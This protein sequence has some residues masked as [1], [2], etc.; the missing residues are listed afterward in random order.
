[1]K[2]LISSRKTFLTI[3]YS[4]II[5]V[6][7]LILIN[8]YFTLNNT[9]F[10]SLLPLLIN[11]VFIIAISCVLI[12][13]LIYFRKKI[14]SVINTINKIGER[15]FDE[16]L[17]EDDDSELGELT[18]SLNKMTAHIRDSYNKLSERVIARSSEITL[19]NAE[20]KKKQKEV[21]RQQQELKSAYEALNESRERYE[22]LI[23]N[24]EGE[25]FFYSQ[26]ARGELLFVS[27]SI[28]NILG[29]NVKEFRQKR[30]S[31]YTNNPINIEAR[32]HFKKSLLGEQQPKYVVELQDSQNNPHLLEISEVPVFN[33]NRE[34]VS[35]EGL[36]HDI[37]ERYQAEELIKEKEEKYRMLFNRASDFIFLYEIDNKHN[38]A[39]KFIEVNDYTLNR[40]GYSREEMLN[41]SPRDLVFENMWENE[42]EI[43]NYERVWQSKEGIFID[44]EISSHRFRIKGQ[45]VAIAVARDIS[46]RKKSEEEIRFMNEE[47]INQKENLEALVDNLTQTQEQ[48]VQSEKMAALGQ[49]IAGIAHEINTPLGAIKASIG[50]LDDSIEK[51]LRELPSILKNSNENNLELLTRIL[52]EANYN[53]KDLTSRERRQKRREISKILTD[54]NID[55][56]DSIADMIIYTGFDEKY[57]SILDLLKSHSALETL[58]IA[59]NFISLLKNTKTINLAAEKA[60]KVVFALKKYAHKDQEE[61]K[62]P[63]DII[64]N[65]E[66]VLT[67]YHN[68]LKQGINVVRNYSVIPEVACYQDELN[69]V[70]TNLIHNAIQAMDQEGTLT[71]DVKTETEM[72]IINIS[73]TGCGIEPD[74]IDRI[75]D[76]FFTTKKQGEGSGLGLDIVKRI[77]EKHEGTISVHS[78]LNA[79][80]TF[81]IKIPVNQNE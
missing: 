7:I 79:G 78:E 74:I 80:S 50:N 46:E 31:L 35:V 33:E 51:A 59:R 8:L 2:R 77:I 72:I 40:L 75:F 70:W 17:P 14:K 71:I 69:Q 62:I 67:L 47:L 18:R 22:K 49:L 5:C 42:S 54:S 19:R 9:Y 48:L 45:N 30:D 4:C 32:E 21:K 23:H 3:I 73:D 41:M 61:E 66:T 60:T 29:Y 25:Y 65:L 53:S 39:G 37:T 55:N 1:M 57:E 16:Q 38:T 26:S 13:I 43:A 20:I 36:A 6:I 28:K 52:S 81:T 15:N 27:P 64:D 56:P 12:F 24:L 11:I 34:L 68:Q 10:S 44:I 76:P 58:N 63:T